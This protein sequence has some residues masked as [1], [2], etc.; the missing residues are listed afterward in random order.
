[1]KVVAAITSILTLG[2]IFVWAI[3]YLINPTP[4]KVDQAGQL[5]TQAA[6]PW[7]IPVLQFLASAS[8]GVLGVVL[9]VTLLYFVSKGQG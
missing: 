3:N 4:E 1:M 2:G 8:L 9:I 5:I 6:I 7:W